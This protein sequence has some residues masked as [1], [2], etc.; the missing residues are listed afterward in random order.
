LEFDG[1]ADGVAKGAADALSEE[2][3]IGWE[4]V[5]DVF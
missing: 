3:L 2:E 4:V 1:A 5:Q